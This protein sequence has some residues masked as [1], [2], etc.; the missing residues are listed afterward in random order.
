MTRN[1][2]K[3]IDMYALVI[4]FFKKYA[5]IINV[6]I[7]LN[8]KIIAFILKETALRALFDE[9]GYNSKGKTQSKEALRQAMVALILPMVE[10]AYGWALTIENAL[11]ENVFNV[12]EDDFVLKQDK[13]IVLANDLLQSLT[14]NVIALALYDITIAEI[15]IAKNAVLNYEAAKETP[16]L[17]RTY[18]KTITATI[19]KELKAADRI[20]KICD[21]LLSGKF[22]DSEPAMLLEYEYSRAL[23]YSVG[24]HTKLTVHVFSDEEHSDVVADASI[25]IASLN[26]K[27]TTNHYGEGEIVQFRGGS[28]ILL[29]KALGFVDKEVAFDIKLGKQVE[30]EVVLV[31]T[32]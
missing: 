10:R 27:E 19:K 31:K 14:D 24:R 21:L 9:Q 16:K 30:L 29:V 17:Q 28:Y 1:Q 12:T 25:E 32:N 26:R 13:L 3:K 5:T 6:F 7:P 15:N 22:G 8:D 4:L 23:Q 18:K 11:L 2:A 20:L